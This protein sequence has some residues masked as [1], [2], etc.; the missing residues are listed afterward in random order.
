MINRNLLLQRDPGR[1]Y[2]HLNLPLL[3]TLEI[4]C[5]DE[6][7]HG[8]VNVKISRPESPGT[9]EQNAAM[10]AL[11]QAYYATGM[12]SARGIFRESPAAFKLWIKMQHG[13]CYCTDMDGVQI[14]VPKSWAAYNKHERSALIEGLLT[15]IGE[16]G[17][18]AESEKLR[19]IIAGM[20]QNQK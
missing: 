6:E 2:Y 11:L 14:K 5:L 4:E 1:A 15:E 16:S 8:Y 7:H 19:E 9:A 10:H 12:H 13:P 18:Y 3:D 17:A 20:E